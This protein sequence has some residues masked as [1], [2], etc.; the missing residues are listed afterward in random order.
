MANQHDRNAFKAGLF[1]VISIFLIIALILGIKGIGRFVVPSQDRIVR[2]A[3]SDDIGGLSPGD[4]VRIGGAKVGVVRGVDIDAGGDSAGPTGK[5]Q[6]GILIEFMMPERYVVRQNAEVN[7]Q[8]TVTGVS[9]LN[10]ASLGDGPPIPQSDV[11]IGQPGGLSSLL[12]SAGKI[13]PEVLGVIKDV[14]GTTLPKVNNAVDS[15]N[16]LIRHVDSKVDPITQKGGNVLDQISSLFGDTK[17]DIRGTIANLNKVTASVRD[18][19]PGILDQTHGALTKVNTAIERTND[20]LLDIKSVAAN[21]RDITASARGIIM[22]NR[23][24]IETMITSLRDTGENLKNATAEIQRSPWRLLYHPSPSE[25]A[26]LNLYDSA[27]QFADGADKLSDAA[28]S[29]RDA[30]Q[31]KSDDPQKLQS[32]LQKLNDSFT[33]FN[34]VENQ[35]WSQVKE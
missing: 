14:R 12:A 31:S 34:E 8:S 19:L 2:F 17:S 6:P 33:H 16:T 3:L 27:R 10:F 30:I 28:T 24:K 11:L 4:D 9:V 21:T 32:L 23:G 29:L 22:G 18:K 20:A 35:L 1:I 25:M 5:Q 26:N 15:S 13:G 7:V